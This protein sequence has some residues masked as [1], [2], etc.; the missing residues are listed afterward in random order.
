MTPNLLNDDGT[1]SMA[2]FLMMSHHG[3]RRD[4]GRMLRAIA[5]DVSNAAA[6]QADWKWIRTDL[7]THHTIE[8]TAMFPGLRKEHPEIGA[9]IDK[10]AADHHRID[11][12]LVRGDAAF[13]QL[14]RMRVAAMDV[15]REL[16]ALLTPHLATEEAE[17]VPHLRATKGFPPPANDAEAT[18]Y[19]Q[20]FAWSSN[21]IAP[22]VLARVDDML[23]PILRDKLP[24]AREAFNHKAARTCPYEMPLASLTP[25]P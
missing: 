23:P 5:R 21:G 8:D 3:F 7:H 1:A 15:L 9:T 16:L 12:L 10:L 14:A 6:L 11:P 4:L 19:A 18:T 22:A 2:T 13:A 24:A 20:G 17:I 25:I